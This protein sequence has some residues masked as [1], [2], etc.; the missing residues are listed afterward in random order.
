MAPPLAPFASLFFLFYYSSYDRPGHSK[1]NLE[2]SVDRYYNAGER[3]TTEILYKQPSLVH[4]VKCRFGVH[5]LMHEL[6]DSTEWPGWQ[7]KQ[8]TVHLLINHRSYLDPHYT[9]Y[10]DFD[11]DNIQT[12]PYMFGHLARLA[13][14]AQTRQH[15]L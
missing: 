1:A 13:I 8:D 14:S 9:E 15:Q 3:P 2:Y 6:Y 5:M 4:R 12:Y 11:E 10:Q 7:Q